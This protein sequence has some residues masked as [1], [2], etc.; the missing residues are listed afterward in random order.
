MH[1]ATGQSIQTARQGAPDG[2]TNPTLLAARLLAEVVEQNGAIKT[3]LQSG[4]FGGGLPSDGILLDNATPTPGDS[5]DWYN[6][7]LVNDSGVTTILWNVRTLIDSSGYQAMAWGDRLLQNTAEADVIDWSSY[8][9]VKVAGAASKPGLGLTGA[10]FT[11][12]TGTTTF[13]LFLIQPSGATAA[14]NW[15]TSGTIFGANAPT[16]FVGNYIDLKLAGASSSKAKL[17]YAGEF[18]TASWIKAG[19]E[20]FYAMSGSTI[21]GAF[22][23]YNVRMQSAIPI[24]WGSSGYGNTVDAGFCRDGA[25][26]VGVMATST[27]TG[28]GGAYGNIKACYFIPGATMATNM[29]EGFVNLAGAAGNPSGTP[30]VTTGFPTFVDSTNNRLYVYIGGTWKY[31]ALT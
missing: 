19:G 27:L 11:G 21:Y 16:G 10:I 2:A 20:G 29:T 6:R 25:K 26:T 14:T 13:P 5:V 31:A 18:E 9:N 15:S 7:R 23:Q 8:A 22:N 3:L 30:T 12:G 24:V 28:A 1:V 17:S 4:G